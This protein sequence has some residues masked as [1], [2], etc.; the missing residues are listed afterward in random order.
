MNNVKFWSIGVLVIT[1]CLLL[2]SAILTGYID[3]FFHYHEPQDSLEY[4][5]NNQ[6]YQNDGIVKH[7]SYDAIITGTSLS[8]NFKPSEFDALFG[9][10]SIKV[11]FSGG[12]FNEILDNL[13]QALE[14]NPHIRYVLF[15]I[16]EWFIYDEKS[17]I[18]ADGEYPTYLYDRNPFNDTNYLLNKDV[19]FNRTLQVLEYTAQGYQTTSFDDY[20]SWS[21]DTGLQAILPK[22]D[23][24]EKTNNQTEQ[25]AQHVRQLEKNLRQSLLWMAEEYPS[26]QFICFFPPYSILNWDSHMQKGTIVRNVQALKQTTEL[27]LEADNIQIFSFYT[28]YDLC[29]N[30][31]L[32]NDQVHYNAQT[33][34]LLLKRMHDGE[35]Q[36]T[37][38]NYEA[39][40]QEVLNFYLNYPYDSIFDRIA[41]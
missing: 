1:L 19:F 4:P 32:Y 30:L 9:V 39:H 20:S 6:R 22:Y 26:T 40:W 2:S 27:L 8:E 11:S 36:L 33:N 31:N 13:K 10:N 34:S 29:T 23:R 24:P 5:L 14:A 16:D 41:P 17:L 15:S 12:T 35:F 38:E 7:F 25:S 28:D 37:K 18:Q 3:P 21:F